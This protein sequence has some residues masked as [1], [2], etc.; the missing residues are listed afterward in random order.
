MSNS[1]L[2]PRTKRQAELMRE[3]FRQGAMYTGGIYVKVEAMALGRYPDPPEPLPSDDQSKSFMDALQA[4]CGDSRRLAE[5]TWNLTGDHAL[6]ERCRDVQRA[7]DRY[8]GSLT[9]R[10]ATEPEA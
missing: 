1:D 3:A 6:Y 10:R 4:L 7:L 5:R 8:R 9:E 2:T